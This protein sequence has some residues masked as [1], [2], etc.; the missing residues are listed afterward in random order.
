M[1]TKRGV[2]AI[3]LLFVL[4]ILAVLIIIVTNKG[5]ALVGPAQEQTMDAERALV[6][7]A[8]AAY[9]L[10]DV[11]ANNA[12]GIPPRNVSARILM[13]DVAAAP[14]VKYLARNTKFRYTWESAGE[15]VMVYR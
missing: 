2:T 14:F 10:M 4:A 3:E 11:D 6:M 8:I 5:G 12:P 15:N 1:S 13:S 9:N 7:T